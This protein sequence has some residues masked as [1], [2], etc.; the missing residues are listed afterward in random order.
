MKADVPEDD[1][2]MIRVALIPV[3]NVGEPMALN[4]RSKSPAGASAG[5]S[6]TPTAM[7]RV[8]IDTKR[9]TTPTQA[10]MSYNLGA[11]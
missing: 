8:I 2:K 3:K 4:P 7:T 10:D 5:L 11:S 1:T 6:C 9:V